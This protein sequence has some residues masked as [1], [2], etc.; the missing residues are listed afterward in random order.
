MKAFMKKFLLLVISCFIS[1][2][3]ATQPEA[4][5]LNKDLCHMVFQAVY[6][7]NKD[8]FPVPRSVY[9]K[10]APTS[11][12]ETA[13]TFKTL[14]CSSKSFGIFFADS[15]RLQLMIPEMS[16]SF[17]CA[18]QDI[19]NALSFN[20]KIR[21]ISQLQESFFNY[22]NQDI[23]YT[24]EKISRDLSRYIAD[25][26]NIN[27]TYRNSGSPITALRKVLT[28]TAF[29]LHTY[30]NIHNPYR[31]HTDFAQKIITALISYNADLYSYQKPDGSSAFHY[32]LLYH[33]DL[34]PLLKDL[35][36]LRPNE[37]DGYNVTP[38]AVLHLACRNNKE[39]TDLILKSAQILLDAGADPTGEY[40]I[41]PSPYGPPEDENNPQ[42]I[43]FMQKAIQNY[44][45]S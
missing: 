37:K 8:L 12:L 13:K 15:Q 17:D 26:V 7:M 4:L 11:L 27:F 3:N 2:I 21:R 34:I 1:L 40:T 24:D 28:K 36:K 25:G 44:T 39:N 38:F 6:K 33:Q 5:V 14:I 23:E 20:K 43:A 42:F 41:K 16:H 10:N 31:M 30:L 45:L 22:C 18:D 9:K 35:N 29:K 19:V 32:I